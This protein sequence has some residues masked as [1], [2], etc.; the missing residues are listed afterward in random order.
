METMTVLSPIMQYGF[1]GLS[2]ILIMIIVWLIN[3]L[4]GVLKDTN[5]IVANNTVAIR[6]VVSLTRDSIKLL[7][8]VHD[9]LIARPCIA[10]KQ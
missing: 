4:L 8:D 1:A 10:E 2:G 9:K 3:K 7:R 5:Q 6:E